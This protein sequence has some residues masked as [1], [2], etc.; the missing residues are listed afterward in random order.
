MF[1]TQAHPE[2]K[3]DMQQVHNAHG[4]LA[5]SDMEIS[6]DLQQMKGKRKKTTVESAADAAVKARH[7]FR[8]MAKNL[9]QEVW[10]SSTVGA[11][12]NKPTVGILKTQQRDLLPLRAAENWTT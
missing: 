8:L 9:Q 4:L 5:N 2:S 3:D 7:Q 1:A 10:S 11:L 6:S 12:T